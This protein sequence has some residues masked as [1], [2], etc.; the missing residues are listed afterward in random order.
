M[1]YAQISNERHEILQK[2]LTKKKERERTCRKVD[3]T[4]LVVHKVKIK[5]KENRYKYL[6]LLRE[7]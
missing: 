6:D 4:L 1:V 5:E 7:N 2:K 3:F